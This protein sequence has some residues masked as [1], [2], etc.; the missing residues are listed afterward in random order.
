MKTTFPIDKKSYAFL[1]A[2]LFVNAIIYGALL[3][4]WHFFADDL[5]NFASSISGTNYNIP[6][7]KP[8]FLVVFAIV[9]LLIMLHSYLKIKN[10]VPPEFKSVLNK[11]IKDPNMPDREVRKI[12]KDVVMGKFGDE[13][14]KEKHA[15]SFM[16][17]ERMGVLEE[18]LKEVDGKR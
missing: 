11:Y 1:L 16:L 15:A 5:L 3:I 14:E 8:I 17:A 12:L 18:I 13:T 7:A 4:L 10:A 9:G 2:E 6:E